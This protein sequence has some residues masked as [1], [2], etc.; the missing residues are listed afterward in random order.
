MNKISRDETQSTQHQT[1]RIDQFAILEQRDADSPYLLFSQIA[2]A[3]ERGDFDA[4]VLIPEGRFVYRQRQLELVEMAAEHDEALMELY[5]S[6]IH[7]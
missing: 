4:G 2:A 6:L 3:V 1:E 7:I 5:L